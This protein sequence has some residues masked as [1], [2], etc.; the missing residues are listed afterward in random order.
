MK[1]KFLHL[2]LAVLVGY[3]G[4]YAIA[5]RHV[6]HFIYGGAEG[7]QAIAFG[8][9]AVLAGSYGVGRHLFLVHGFMP[10]KRRW[11]AGLVCVYI[12]SIAVPHIV[13]RL[14]I[15]T[16]TAY[17]VVFVAAP[18]ALAAMAGWFHFKCTR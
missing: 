4:S 15:S 5:L 2:L 6:G 10:M 14:D 1:T 9:I 17:L 13:I 3:I 8:V 7:G 18:L 16:D 12:L 11:V